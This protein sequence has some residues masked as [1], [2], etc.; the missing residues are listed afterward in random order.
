MESAPSVPSAGT[1]T[2]EAAAMKSFVVCNGEAVTTHR[3]A[4]VMRDESAMFRNYEMIVIPTVVPSVVVIPIVMPV[5]AAVVDR[6]TP[7]APVAPFTRLIAAA[8]P[9]F[10]RTVGRTITTISVSA[11]VDVVASR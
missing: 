6:I 9:G 2:M 4:E 5:M 11:G 7:S 8:I 10:C 3:R 1:A